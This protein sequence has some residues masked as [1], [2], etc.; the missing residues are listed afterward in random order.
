MRP[1]GVKKSKVTAGH[2]VE[3]WCGEGPLSMRNSS[4]GVRG[5][6]RNVKITNDHR[7]KR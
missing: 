6:G 5:K 2:F 3:I 4:V 7:R 1:K